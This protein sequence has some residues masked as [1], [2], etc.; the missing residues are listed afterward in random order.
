MIF[1][2]SIITLTSG[3]LSILALQKC[4]NKYEEYIM[5]LYDSDEDDSALED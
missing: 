5:S 2:I 1:I 3:I 4:Y